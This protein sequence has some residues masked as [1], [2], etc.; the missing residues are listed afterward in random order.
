MKAIY[1]FALSKTTGFQTV[2][3]PHVDGS[4]FSYEFIHVEMWQDLPTLFMIIEPQPDNFPSHPIR[5]RILSMGEQ[6][7]DEEYEAM[8]Q[9]TTYGAK[10]LADSKSGILKLSEEIAL[11]HH[12]K[13]DGTGYPNGIKGEDI[14]WSGRIVALADVFDALVS[15]RR[16]KEAWPIE[17]VVNYIKELSGKH[18]DPR[19][20]EAFEQS[21]EEILKIKEK[22]VPQK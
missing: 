20:V 12:E 10:I 1:S 2:E 6:F 19:V 17:E 14:P 18:F 21:L 22:F 3:I 9:H 16:Y 7:T 4:H 11:T 15:R 5:I 13:F 8:K